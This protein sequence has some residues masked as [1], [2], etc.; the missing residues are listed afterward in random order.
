MGRRIPLCG[1]TVDALR[2]DEAVTL[3]LEWATA[4][5][6]RLRYVVTPNV[7]HAVLLQESQDLRDAYDGADLVLA[8]GVPLIVLAK[9]VGEPL[10]ERVAGSDLVPLM[11]ARAPKGLRVFLLGAGPGV[12]DRAAARIHE[13]WPGVEVVGVYDPPM[14]FDR[15]PAATAHAVER[16]NAAA[17]DLL[18]IGLGAPKQEKWVHAHRD[19]LNARVAVCAGATIDFLAGE[20]ARAPEWMQRHGL[21]WAHRVWSEPRRLGPRYARD[22]VA[23]PRVALRE[24]ADRRRRGDGG[25]NGHGPAGH[26]AVGHDST[27]HDS[28][29]HGTNGNGSVSGADVTAARS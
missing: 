24:F 27:G 17:P 25:S 21:E 2:L 8:D 6:E 23:F 29:G 7:H 10:P 12:G 22:A 13:Q 5:Q 15:D 11:L 3:M 19:Q 26:D 18:V 28:N 1:A 16:V 14:G 9:L 20:L 4:P